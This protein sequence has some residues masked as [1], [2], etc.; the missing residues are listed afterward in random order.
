[1]Q[2]INKLGEILIRKIKMSKVESE[3]IKTT[4]INIEI[5][6]NLINKDKVANNKITV[7]IPRIASKKM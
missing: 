1:M 3:P 6:D 2:N 5:S 4:E 7:E